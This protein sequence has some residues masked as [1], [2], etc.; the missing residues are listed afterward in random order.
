MNQPL[1]SMAASLLG[2]YFPVS[3]FLLSFALFL[4]Q[5]PAVQGQ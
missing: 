4:Q 3:Q 5:I 1:V 2:W